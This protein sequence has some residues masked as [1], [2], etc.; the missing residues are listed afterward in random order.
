[1]KAILSSTYDDLYLFNL[2][3]VTWAWK[4]LSVDVICFMPNFNQAPDVQKVEL[5][6]R[7]CPKTLDFQLF[8]CPP[9]KTATYAQ[10][11][12]LFGCYANVSN[13]ETII[14]SDVDMLV[15]KLPYVSP[16]ENMSTVGYDLTPEKQYPMCYASGLA[17]CWWEMFGYESISYQEM[18]DKHLAHENCENMRGNLWCRDQELLYNY[19]NKVPHNKISRARPGTQFASNRV[20]RDDSFWE[21]RLNEF[22]LDAHLWRPLWEPANFEKL[23]K[24]LRFKWPEEDFG[25]VIEYRNEYIKLL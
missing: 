11:S 14:T 24:L 4:R 21:E 25:W 13:Y 23:L 17:L 18:L 2:P 19:M 6:A 1:M 20:D 22:T 12:R 15:F 7:N 8:N 3:I 5:V 16:T 10:V 9:E